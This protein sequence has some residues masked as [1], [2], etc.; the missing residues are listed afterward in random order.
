MERSL[1]ERRCIAH[2]T[3]SKLD[4]NG[5]VQ[6]HAGDAGTD[7]RTNAILVHNVVILHHK[8]IIEVCPESAMIPA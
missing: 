7:N 8:R 2:S 6:Q 3:L 5:E 4:A 1:F